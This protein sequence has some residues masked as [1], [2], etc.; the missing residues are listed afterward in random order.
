MASEPQASPGE[1]ASRPPAGRRR[2]WPLG[3]VAARW[4]EAHGLSYR[5]ALGE[6]LSLLEGHPRCLVVACDRLSEIRR[7][8]DA[9]VMAERRRQALARIRALAEG[10]GDLAELDRHLLRADRLAAAL[11]A[12]GRPVPAFLPP[13]AVEAE[14]GPAPSAPPA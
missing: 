12:A 5:E 3:E 13:P 14:T 6:L 2:A 8:L 4:A 9:A 7:G 11:L 1:M 10:E